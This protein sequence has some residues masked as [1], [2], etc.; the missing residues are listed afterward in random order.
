MIE[1]AKDAIAFGDPCLR[2]PAADR[3]EASMSEKIGIAVAARL[4]DWSTPGRDGK[5]CAG[6]IRAFSPQ[7]GVGSFLVA[8]AGSRFDA[9]DTIASVANPEAG[10]VSSI[11]KRI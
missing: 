9:V 4:P 5:V 1:F 8:E 10:A 2:N 6:G 3:V 11:R 7:R